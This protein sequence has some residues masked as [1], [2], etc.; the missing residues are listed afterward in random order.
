[1]RSR[2]LSASV[3]V[4]VVLAA[5]AGGA[6]G[7][8][9]GVAAGLRSPDA[10]RRG[11]A[12]KAAARLAPEPLRTV[13]SEAQALP[14]EPETWARLLLGLARE[15]EAPRRQEFVRALLRARQAL[16]SGTTP[17]PMVGR[18]AGEAPAA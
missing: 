13:L 3:A 1:M 2:R 12:A 6:Q 7:E 16:R 5:L 8:D 10:A 9:S 11:E 17:S 15:A 18:P 4:L 14:G